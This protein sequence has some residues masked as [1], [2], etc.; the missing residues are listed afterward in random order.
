MN[1]DEKNL[2]LKCTNNACFTP[3]DL[4]ASEC[5]PEMSLAILHTEGVYR[6]VIRTVGTFSHVMYKLP[7]KEF[8]HSKEMSILEYLTVVSESE[9]H[10]FEN[11]NIVNT[12]PILSLYSAKTNT[13]TYKR[14]LLLMQ[15]WQ[16]MII[17]TFF[18][19]S[20]L[21]IKEK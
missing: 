6:F 4:A 15:G 20:I 8:H 18:L 19:Q 16:V 21:S 13:P 17:G 14:G 11:T 10:R 12:E 1:E 5:V 3:L 7:N 9:L 2:I